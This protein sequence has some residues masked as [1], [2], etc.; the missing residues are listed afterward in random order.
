MFFFR[1]RDRKKSRVREGERRRNVVNE[2]KTNWRDNYERKR[3]II[4]KEQENGGER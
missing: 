1:N 3:K 4:E 2:R